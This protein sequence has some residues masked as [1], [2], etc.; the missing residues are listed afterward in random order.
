MRFHNVV[1]E[2]C[3]KVENAFN[4]CARGFSCC[5]F[6]L[7]F[8]W[9]TDY[10]TAACFEFFT[11]PT[12]IMEFHWV[13]KINSTE[14]GFRSDLGDY[15]WI[16]SVGQT[17]QL[18]KA[19]VHNK[20]EHCG[21]LQV[22]SLCCLKIDPNSYTTF[23]YLILKQGHNVFRNPQTLKMTLF[24]TTFKDSCLLCEAM[25]FEMSKKVSKNAQWN[26][27]ATCWI[28]SFHRIYYQ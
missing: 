7:F 11:P 15:L 1:T 26:G 25:D 14:L 22:H 19:Q 6:L 27:W 28:W 24:V 4:N 3:S 8:L 23:V 2:N 18:S 20:H 5:L 13:D 9:L 16:L 21:L 17:T 10:N 12:D